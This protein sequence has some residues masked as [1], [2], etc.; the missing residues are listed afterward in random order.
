M[1]PTI[2]CADDIVKLVERLKFLPFF[3]NGIDCFSIEDLCPGELWFARDVDGPWE[4]KGPIIRS[5]GC[6]Y[7]KFFGGK[8]GFVSLD[9]FPD[10][11]N[12]RRDGYDFDSRKEEGL[13]P[14]RDAMLMDRLNGDMLSRDLK[15]ACGFEKGFD[16]TITRLQM[17][18]YVCVSDFVYE[19]DKSGK[20]YGW[21]V[22]R[23]CTPETLY[24]YDFVRSSYRVKPEKSLQKLT[25]IL[26]SSY[27][28][29]TEK[30]AEAIL[31]GHSVTKK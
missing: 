20:P 27:K 29:I 15:S 30:Q 18:T 8:A 25:Y 17:Q 26:C 19:K 1:R 4:W 22:A 7:G 21:G 9:V 14:Y 31:T 5:G 3:A 24:G 23:Y 6:A 12:L 2:T 16:G 10:F 11:A 28:N 13:A